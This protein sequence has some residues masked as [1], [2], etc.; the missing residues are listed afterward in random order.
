MAI[1]VENIHGNNK[2]TTLLPGNIVA[3]APTQPLPMSLLD[4][5][6]V[7]AKM[8]LIHSIV[9]KV[10]Q[11]AKKKT[12]IALAPALVET[13]SRLLVYMEIESL[14]IKAFIKKRNR[15]Q[16][17][18]KRVRE[19][20]RRKCE[21]HDVD[22]HGDHGHHGKHW[23]GYPDKHWPGYPDKHWPGHHHYRKPWNKSHKYTKLEL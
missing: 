8:S 23:P 6:T 5:L 12:N 22:W 7:H 2:N 13:Y 21:D 1:L 16:R 4:S 18:E 10:I 14:G 17:Y 11:M 3:G 9:T 20:S 15:Q 19:P